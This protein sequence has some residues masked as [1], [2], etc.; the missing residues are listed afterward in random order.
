MIE[1]VSSEGDSR[2]GRREFLLGGGLLLL[3]GSLTRQSAAAPPSLRTWEGVRA[4]FALA[5]GHPNFAAWLLASHP[6]PV[7]QAIERHRQGLDADAK[8]YLDENEGPLEEAVRDAAARYLHVQ[9]DDVALTDSTTMG[10]GL[11]YG[12]LRLRPGDELLT[13]EHDFY[14]THEALRLRAQRS[15][16]VVKKIRLFRSPDQATVDGILSAIRSALTPRTRVLALTWVHSA[17]GMKLPVREIARLVVEINANRSPNDRVLFCLDS[18]HGLVVENVSLQELGCDVF[19]AGCHKWLFGPRGTGIVW[20]S[21]AAWSRIDATIPTF[22]GASYGA[23]LRGEVPPATPPGP[24]MTPGGFHSFE[25]RWALAEAFQFH[26]A[27]GKERVER[28]THALASR[29]KQGVAGR[30][31]VAVVTPM[32]Q[33]LSAGIVCLRP[34]NRA[35]REVVE[36]LWSRHGIVASVT[37]YATAYLRLGP[38]IV[39]SPAEVDRA[40]AAIAELA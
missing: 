26:V 4:Q 9:P 33:E 39:N 25:H 29:L 1:E 16:A 37:P 40:V 23:W 20:A 13:S 15:G 14:A 18:V 21:P 30:R 28:R 38:S 3:P 36:L 32:S 22:D 2:L 27:V 10:L 31:N 17:T 11:V 35:P 6:L 8:R 24:R 19:V 7:R 12:G 5:A 34:G